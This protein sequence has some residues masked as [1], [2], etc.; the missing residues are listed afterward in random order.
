MIGPSRVANKTRPQIPEKLKKFSRNNLHCASQK[1]FVVLEEYKEITNPNL[2]KS[3]A[4]ISESGIDKAC[5]APNF[6]QVGNLSK[7]MT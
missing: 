1:H 3:K 5:I 6:I 7:I 4:E 2:V